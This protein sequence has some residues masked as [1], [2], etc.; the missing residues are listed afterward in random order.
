LM[1]WS[2]GHRDAALAA[3]HE[4]GHAFQRLADEYGGDCT[5]MDGENGLRIN[6]TTD[7]TGAKWKQWL[8]FDQMPG[9]GMQG[10]FE[11]AQ[12][13]DKGVWRPSQDSVMNQLSRSPSFNSISLE[14]AV[15]VIYEKV[16]PID[17][18]TPSDVTMPSVLEVD[19]V[20][21]AVIA[22]DWSVDG[23]VVSERG[24]RS[25]DASQQGLASGSHM[26]SARAYDDTD[27][28][29]GDRAELE[30]TVQWTIQLP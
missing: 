3:M 11:G 16:K 28:V 26:V 30:Q 17:T 10:T 29:R 14:Q 4:G 25:F 24:G 15:R 21:P 12:Y 2:G 19:V 13:C 1:V 23:K 6:V 9:T 18:S 20:D 22:I 5:F 7:A 27:W 8:G